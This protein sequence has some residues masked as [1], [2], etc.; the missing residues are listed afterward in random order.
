MVCEM[1]LRKNKI[2]IMEEKEDMT[3]RNA[4]ND[5][6]VATLMKNIEPL[7]YTF[8]R[9]LYEELLRYSTDQLGRLCWELV[10]LL[11]KSKVLITSTAQCIEIFL[12]RLWRRQRAGCISMRWCII[13]AMEQ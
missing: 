11:K 13:G 5:L 3:Q 12:W 8:S 1:L 4:L 10:E 6:S 9:E 2:W 7:G